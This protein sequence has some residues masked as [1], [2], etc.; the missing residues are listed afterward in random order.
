MSIEYFIFF[1]DMWWSDTAKIKLKYFYTQRY[2]DVLTIK[3]LIFIRTH[4]NVPL[5]QIGQYKF[6]YINCVGFD[7]FCFDPVIV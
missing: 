6:I 2:Q 5:L 3:L 7:C 4:L 1:S